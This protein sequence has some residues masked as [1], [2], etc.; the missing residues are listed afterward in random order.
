MALS[1]KVFVTSNTEDT[2]IAPAA[3]TGDSDSP[4][5]GKKTPAATGNNNSLYPNAQNKLWLMVNDF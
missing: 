4:D 5:S 1:R 3:N 2:A